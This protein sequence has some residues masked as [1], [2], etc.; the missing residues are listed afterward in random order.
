MIVLSLRVPS[1]WSVF[2]PKLVI[3]LIFVSII[4]ERNLDTIILEKCRYI[5]N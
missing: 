4:G 2:E 3:G 5:V 1:W